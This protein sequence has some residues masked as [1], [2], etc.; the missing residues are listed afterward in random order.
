[1]MGRHDRSESLFYYF[2][3]EEQVAED[4]LL[5]LIDRGRRS[6][7]SKLELPQSDVRCSSIRI[8]IV[9]GEHSSVSQSGDARVCRHSLFRMR[10]AR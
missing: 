7:E 5:R 1:M 2:R 8:A 6:H 3:L 4:H 10:I 9:V